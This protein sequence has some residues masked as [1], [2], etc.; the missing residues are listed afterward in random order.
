[1]RYL[2]IDLGDK[3]TG[4]AVG[5]DR[6][7]L[8]MPVGVI[9]TPIG[10]GGGAELLG[11]IVRAVAEHLGPLAPGGQGST[12]APGSAEAPGSG[13][14]PGPAG[15][16]IVVGLP[17]NMDGTEGAR[18]ASVRAFAARVQAATGRTV[19][20]QDERLS[21]AAADWSMA[22]S[23]LT[24]DQKKGKRD[25]L[26]AAGILGD[27]LNRVHPPERTDRASNHAG[28]DVYGDDGSGNP[29]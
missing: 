6:T 16:E 8:V 15:D 5:D 27:Y 13:V 24:R 19:R 28:P 23:G 2:C 21:T 12:G 11:A 22:R 9:E 26:A 18:A 20:F 14:V 1:V 10:A 3:R 25:A 17:L 29:K 4:L 7:R